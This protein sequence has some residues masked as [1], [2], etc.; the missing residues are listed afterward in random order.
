MNKAVWLGA[1][2][3]SILAAPAF[4]QTP[5][6]GA[7]AGQGVLVFEPAFFAD[8]RP[9][10]VLDMLSRLPGFNLEFGDSGSRG[11]AGA[12]GNVLIDGQRPAI[13]SEGLDQYLRRISKI[14]KPR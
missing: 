14:F 12:G 5:T 11:Y 13:K 10:T 9:D 8:A 3:L 4:A 1:A 6:P 7:Q 2:A